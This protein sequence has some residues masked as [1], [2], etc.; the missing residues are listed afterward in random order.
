[1]K[2]FNHKTGKRPAY[3]NA[4]LSSDEATYTHRFNQV[5]NK[6]GMS[7][8]LMGYSGLTPDTISKIEDDEFDKSYEN[9]E[10]KINGHVITQ[11]NSRRS[12]SM[13]PPQVRHA[14]ATKSKFR[15]EAD[16]DFKNG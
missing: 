3:K 8:M 4:R 7:E 5:E 12:I 9:G 2:Q 1:M 13:A 10:I 6:R 15:E 11:T 14:A 16:N